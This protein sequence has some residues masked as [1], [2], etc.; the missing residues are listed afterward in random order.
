MPP[1]LGEVGLLQALNEL[2]ENI[3]QVNELSISIHWNDVN[4]ND[5]PN[6]L[7]HHFPYHTGTTEQ[8]NKT[9]G[10]KT[11]DHW[12]IKIRKYLIHNR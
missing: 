3:K 6:K 5:L 2:A 7:K 10:C 4:E 8:R 12:H 1:S 11:R 9:C